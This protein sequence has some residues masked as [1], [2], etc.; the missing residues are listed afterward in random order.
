MVNA[1]L[2]KGQFTERLTYKLDHFR[3]VTS[4][5]EFVDLF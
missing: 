1:L 2:P 4:L 5:A 3:R